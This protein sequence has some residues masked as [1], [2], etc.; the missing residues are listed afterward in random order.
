MK[1]LPV[2]ILL[3]IVTA[4]SPSSADNSMQ[5]KT[6]STEIHPA[7]TATARAS[8]P[9]FKP[10]VIF[11]ATAGGSQRDIGINLIQTSDGGF[12][13][14]GYTSSFGEGSEDMYLVRLDAQGEELW[15]Q[16]YGGEG[17]DNGWDL[18]E[19][20]DGGFVLLGF[21]DSFSAGDM[22]MY[23]VRTDSE[24]DELW[25]RTYG[26]GEDEYGWALARS[27]DGGYALAGQ[28]LSF[29]AG[30]ND[31]LL[32]KVDSEG[33]EQWLQSY[34]GE[35]RDRLFAITAADDGGFVLA[36][37]T[38]SFGKGSRDAYMV[39]TDSLGAIDWELVI[40][41]TQDDVAHA[42]SNTEDGGY[43]VTGYTQNYEAS[44]YDGMLLK[45]SADGKQE[46][47][48]VFGGEAEDRTIS[49]QQSA[50]GGY[51]I[52]GYSYSFG[53][54]NSDAYLVKLDSEGEL[55]WQES[56]GGNAED[57]G[58]TVIQTVDGN[59]LMVGHSYSQGEGRGDFY[60][61]LVEGQ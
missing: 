43:I 31:G 28:T 19:V 27:D 15:S 7:P 59:Y 45:I 3:F 52:A 37:I 14:L 39:K 35:D 5:T 26:G 8:E 11:E 24:G 25:S 30:G 34:G 44:V 36:G 57:G 53:L 32:V 4:C 40:G 56:Y 16:T 60:Y 33:Q 38:R 12:A 29:G 10:R 49:G 6:I 46:W 48:S 22:D 58:Y 50:E 41:E 2:F 47:M 20:A 21:S 13:L 42:I 61:V 18:L 9:P 51:I 1:S 17:D 54:G 23:L 55:E